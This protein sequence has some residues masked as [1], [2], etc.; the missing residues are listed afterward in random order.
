MKKLLFLSIFVY[1]INCAEAVENDTLFILSNVLIVT[2]WVT[3]H[4]LVIHQDY[5][6]RNIILGKHPSTSS[7]NTY[8][9]GAIVTNYLLYRFLPKDFA[10][11]YLSI[12]IIIETASVGVNTSHFVSLSYSF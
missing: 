11:T 9:V 12:V 3:T 4:E 7:V 2:D 1:Q 10:K 6:E 8:F 5:H